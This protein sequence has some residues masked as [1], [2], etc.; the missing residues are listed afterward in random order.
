MV[1]KVKCNSL[2]EKKC[3]KQNKICNP[4]SGRCVNL[5]Y[6]YK[7]KLT[8]KVS[9]STK[10][11]ALCQSQGKYCNSKTGQCKS[12]ANKQVIP[13]KIIKDSTSS[14]VWNLANLRMLWNKRKSPV[15][16]SKCSTLKKKSC[17]NIGKYCNRE[18]GLCKSYATR[19]KSSLNN[20]KTKLPRKKP[21]TK[22]VKCSNEVINKCFS[23]NLICNPKTGRCIK[24]TS[25][26]KPVKKKVVCS[27]ST[28]NKCFSENKICNP[29]TGRCIKKT[30]TL[31]KNLKPAKKV[32]ILSKKTIIPS[33][34]KNLTLHQIKENYKKKDNLL[35]QN[36]AT[37]GKSNTQL[38]KKTQTKKTKLPNTMKQPTSLR[39]QT[40]KNLTTNLNTKTPKCKKGFRKNKITGEC[41]KTVIP[42][43]SISETPSSSNNSSNKDILET[44]SSSNLDISEILDNKDTS[45]SNDLFSSIENDDSLIVNTPESNNSQDE[46]I[47]VIPKSIKKKNT[48]ITL[49]PKNNTVISE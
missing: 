29:K 47:D 20:K 14:G 26:L 2:I 12:Y 21:Q 48:K 35:F 13:K 44:P 34:N 3:N 9:C 10:K 31:K 37:K 30:T 1:A 28:I 5:D 23:Q 15:K 42:T 22:K 17:N 39:T 25:T 27:L 11:K 36:L 6:I 43:L 45:E 18:T 38:L 16:K 8:K 41:E 19:K 33:T 46:V 7:K 32:Q 24:K 40:L 49:L 4:A